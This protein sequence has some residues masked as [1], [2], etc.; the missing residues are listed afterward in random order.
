MDKLANGNELSPAIGFL[1]AGEYAEAQE[2][3][4][5]FLE[6]HPDNPESLSLLS[7]VLLL[8]N[9]VLE[10]ERSLLAAATISPDLL[11]VHLNQARLWL[12]QAKPVEALEKA[13][14]GYELAPENPE[15]CL[16][17]AACL[18]A[19]QRD[20]EA[21]PLLEKALRAKPNYAE[22]F[23]SR[24]LILLRKKDITGAIKD[25]E[26]AVSFKPHLSKVWAL[27]GSL[28][29]HSNNLPGAIEAQR[30]AH[31][32]D[33]TNVDYMV[34]LGEFLR[35]DEK[36]E[37]AITILS[38]A[39][40]LDCQNASA[41]TNLGVALQ[42]S[43]KL[44]DAKAAYQK[45]L[46]I[47]PNSAAVLNNLGFFSR[48]E[49][50]WHAALNYFKKAVEIEPDLAVGHYNI[51]FVLRHLR[52]LE[53]AEASSRRAIELRSDF[54]EAHNI[55][56][57]TLAELGS[58]EE[59]KVAFE[60]AIKL[61]PG[62][63]DALFNMSGLG[64]D[65]QVVEYWIDKC[66][67]VN[68]DNEGAKLTKASLNFYQGNKTP[69]NGLLRSELKLHPY[70]RSYSWVF[71]L[72]NLP[73]LY[74]NTWQFFDAI[75]GQSVRSRPFYEFGVWRGLSFKYLVKFLKKGFGFDTFTGL[76]ED[77]QIG[78]RVEPAGTYSA[79]G[80]VP[81]IEG[82]EFIVG[83]FED[84]LPGFFSKPRPIA[85]IINFDADLY[86][87]TICSL[88]FSKSVIDGKTILVF[89][90]FLMNENWEQDEYKAL[91]EFCETNKCSYEVMAVSFFS[92][93]VAVKLIGI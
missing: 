55:L 45:A 80:N 38:S 73:D 9:Q 51:S 21:L 84:T 33:P 31:E 16:V 40:K 70:V 65:I 42:G 18:S 64:D 28:N 35:Q 52:R 15:S 46:E 68:K 36:I 72:P 32:N 53:E 63:H 43:K 79:G 75:I 23:A 11:S 49:R 1:E 93:Q 76:P 82:G 39:T 86:S 19:N 10:S 7:K 81:D 26:A 2:W 54:P 29:Y 30:T 4:T 62:Y 12:K 13:R 60:Q 89:D 90:E 69:F 34:S 67:E 59:A 48:G 37:E 14:A 88:N 87:A 50:D 44:V 78:K 27:L 5:N 47:N 17:L 66:I 83:K 92:K 24:A 71:N 91:S 56:G 85:S 77:W 8:D 57:I 58:L 41:W 3:L 74:F 6:A 25:S 20:H 61:K 22:A